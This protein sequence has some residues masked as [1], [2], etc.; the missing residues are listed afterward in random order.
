MISLIKNRHLVQPTKR[1]TTKTFKAVLCWSLLGGITFD[2][3]RKADR[4]ASPT[5][6]AEQI[7]R[8]PNEVTVGST[9]AESW[10]VF[11]AIM[12]A[13]LLGMSLY[14]FCVAPDDPFHITAFGL[15]GCVLGWRSYANLSRCLRLT[16]HRKLNTATWHRRTLTGWR[17]EA[18][19]LHDLRVVMIPLQ[20]MTIPTSTH[21]ETHRIAIM[22]ASPDETAVLASFA[23]DQAAADALAQI[24]RDTGVSTIEVCHVNIAIW[25]AIFAFFSRK[26]DHVLAN[27]T[28]LV[29]DQAKA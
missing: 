4:I 14:T 5:P 6:N 29:D 24:S 3:L 9:S 8:E 22:L 12:G 11:L 7:D 19:S 28:P 18:F 13:T 10:V 25:T 21:S 17:S 16:V 15:S 2:G 23:S 26:A 1:M 20:F 27:A